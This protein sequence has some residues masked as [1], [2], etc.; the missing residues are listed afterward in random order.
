MNQGLILHP[1][2]ILG[3]PN[4]RLTPFYCAKSR[5]I[6]RAPFESSHIQ[7]RSFGRRIYDRLFIRDS[8]YASISLSDSMKL[9]DRLRQLEHRPHYVLSSRKKKFIR[10]ILLAFVLRWIYVVL[11]AVLLRN[12]PGLS[13]L[14]KWKNTFYLRLKFSIISSIFTSFYGIFFL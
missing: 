6:P 4:P 1:P 14:N 10:I 3:S 7:R 13:T 2:I 11:C 5:V 9:S 12:F 8:R